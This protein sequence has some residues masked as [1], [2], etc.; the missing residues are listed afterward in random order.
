M[1]KI[2]ILSTEISNITFIEGLNK[3]NDF[4]KEGNEKHY[5]VTPNPEI[6]MMAE[7]DEQYRQILNK[8]D[9]ALCDGMGTYLAGKI[10]KTSFKERITGIDFMLG[11]CQLAEKEGYSIGLLGGRKEIAWQVGNK[12]KKMLPQL[13]IAYISSEWREEKPKNTI[14][15]L[16]VAFGAPKQEKWIAE[17]LSWIPVKVAMGVGGSFDYISGLTV[18]APSCLRKI[19]AEWLFRLVI[20]PWR[21]KRQLALLFFGKLIIEKALKNFL[22][23]RSK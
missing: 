23:T 22:L 20:Q 9:I 18:R 1:E 8:A 5:I 3:V 4:L 11:L 17:N 7:Q 2:K 14:G 12:L 15:I 13:N 10:F 6:I 16:F 21:F 19:G